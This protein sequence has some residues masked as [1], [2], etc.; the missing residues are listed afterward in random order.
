MQNDGNVEKVY[1]LFFC[2][3]INCFKFQTD[4]LSFIESNEKTA[5]CSFLIHLKQSQTLMKT[6]HYFRESE[7]RIHLNMDQ[8]E[9]RPGKDW[10]G[11]RREGGKREVAGTRRNRKTNSQNSVIFC[12]GKAQRGGNHDRRGENREYKVAG[13]F[14][15]V[16]KII[17][18]YA[19]WFRVVLYQLGSKLSLQNFFAA[20]RLFCSLR[21]QPVFS[22]SCFTRREKPLIFGGKTR[23]ENTSAFAG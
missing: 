14:R 11:G 8:G 23:A 7:S 10:G 6:E 22:G 16:F 13:M 9:E 3:Q 19:V 21:E 5:R 1:L 17:F 15:A 18:V 2:Y 12:N 20:K 4:P